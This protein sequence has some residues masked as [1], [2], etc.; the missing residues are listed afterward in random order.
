MG[1]AKYPDEQ[2]YSLAINNYGGSQ[3]AYTTREVSQG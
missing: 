1:T 3:N 2:E